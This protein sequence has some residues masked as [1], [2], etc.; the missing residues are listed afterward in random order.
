MASLHVTVYLKFRSSPLLQFVLSHHQVKL[1]SVLVPS[2]KRVLSLLSYINHVILR[3]MV[4]EISSQ[5]WRVPQAT[6]PTALGVQ[7][8][9]ERCGCVFKFTQTGDWAVGKCFSLSL[10]LLQESYWHPE[11]TEKLLALSLC[12]VEYGV[13]RTFVEGKQNYSPAWSQCTPPKWRL[14]ADLRYSCQS[15]D[16]SCT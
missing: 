11:M 16:S 2:V 4:A 9:S 6:W 3:Y 13:H 1:I 12:L 10:Q 14:L 15:L 7:Q 5:E 8:S